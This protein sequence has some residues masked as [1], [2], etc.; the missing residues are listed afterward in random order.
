MK[1]QYILRSVDGN[2]SVYEVHGVQDATGIVGKYR[3]LSGQ[4]IAHQGSWHNS[5]RFYDGYYHVFEIG[6]IQ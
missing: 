2:Q 4:G 1:K 5:G 6:P 3:M